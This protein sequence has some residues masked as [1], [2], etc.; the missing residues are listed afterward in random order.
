MKLLFVGLIISSA[1]LSFSTQEPTTSNTKLIEG[2][3]KGI[4]KTNA[5]PS[6]INDYRISVIAIDDS[7]IEIS[8]LIPNQTIS[9]RVIVEPANDEID[10][11]GNPVML[12]FK[13][14][15]ANFDRKGY[16][17]PASGILHYSFQGAITDK[18]NFE[19]F[20]G[21]KE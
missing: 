5:M 20:T 9:F 10:S 6:S 4:Y 11:R 2:M 16:F 14:P 12:N 21:E 8:P 15:T 1:F 17:Y 13:S 3:Y 19:I 7:I 18:S